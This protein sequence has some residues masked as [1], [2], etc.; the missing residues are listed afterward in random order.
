[1]GLILSFFPDGLQHL[2]GAT[3][4]L[5]PLIVR[6]TLVVVPN[7]GIVLQRPCHGIGGA[8]V[9]LILRDGVECLDAAG[10]LVLVVPL[11]Q[12][13][14]KCFFV[15]RGVR[16]IVH[17]RQRLVQ[18]GNLIL[19]LRLLLGRLFPGHPARLPAEGVEVGPG[20]VC[21]LK[22]LLGLL[23]DGP[24]VPGDKVHIAAEKAG[25]PAGE[26]EDLRAV[27]GGEG[28]LQLVPEVEDLLGPFLLPQGVQ[29]IAEEARHRAVGME[30]VHEV[31]VGVQIAVDERHTAGGTGHHIQP[32]VNVRVLVGFHFVAKVALQ[33]GLR[34]GGEVRSLFP[35]LVR[36]LGQGEGRLRLGL[37]QH[38]EIVDVPHV[39]DLT[40]HLVGEG[41]EHPPDPAF[42]LSQ[43]GQ[44]LFA[45]GGDGEAVFPL[46]LQP[47]L[48]ILPGDVPAVLGAQAGIG[49]GLTAHQNVPVL[50]YLPG[51]VLP[52][53]D[54]LKQLDL[55]PLRGE[56]QL[57][58]FTVEAHLEGDFVKNQIQG[59]LHLGHEFRA[60]GVVLVFVHHSAQLGLLLGKAFPCRFRPLPEAL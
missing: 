55:V 44:Q 46:L 32:P 2:N 26:G 43:H 58:L 34:I 50:Q 7:D 51:G 48:H 53:V 21:T 39:G 27:P 35:Q 37:I 28:L 41:G 10:V 45:V 6:G 47:D 18:L 3:Q 29:G 30:S 4:G 22:E 33:I 36:Q 16:D 24:D 59:F 14:E 20:D 56:D 60:P 13:L 17:A 31:V 1:M 57:M 38:V 11:L 52:E 9:S 5:I 25:G 42:L 49:R 19:V 15:L 12:L 40:Q 8:V 54:Q 23:Q